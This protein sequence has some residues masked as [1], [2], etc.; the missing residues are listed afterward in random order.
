MPI[1]INFHYHVSSK[2]KSNNTVV[3]LRKSINGNVNVKCYD[4]NDVI[5]Y[6]LKTISHNGLC[7]LT[8]LHVSTEKHDNIMDEN[9]RGEI[10]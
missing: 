10:I 7:L 2:T 5:P 6:S 9:N 4:P 8:P 1:T 3:S